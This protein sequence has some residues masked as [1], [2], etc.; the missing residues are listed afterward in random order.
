MKRSL[1]ILKDYDGL[2]TAGRIELMQGK[3]GLGGGAD[4]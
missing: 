3:S 1:A 4:R 2:M